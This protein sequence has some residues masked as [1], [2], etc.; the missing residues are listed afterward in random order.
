MGS[1]PLKCSRQYQFMFFIDNILL[2][3]LLFPLIGIFILLFVPAREEKLIKII[4][5]NSACFSFISSLLVWGSFQ[6]STG[7][8]QFVAK[9]YWFLD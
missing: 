1:N 6:K 3:T 2:L 8:F 4:A 7:Y 9:Y 5:F